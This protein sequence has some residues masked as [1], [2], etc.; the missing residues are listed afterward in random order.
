MSV[1]SVLISGPTIAN[2]EDL[3]RKLQRIALVKLSL[4]NSRIETILSGKKV[5]LLLLEVLRE[6]TS[7]TELIKKIK[8]GFPSLAI[9]LIDGDTD[10]DVVARAFKYGV[11]DA[12]RK[13]YMCDL[14]AERVQAILEHSHDS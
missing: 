3:V 14:I 13:P 10:R 2:D 5:D 8:E 6:N 9:I 7:D 12:F 4:Q 11:K 1:P